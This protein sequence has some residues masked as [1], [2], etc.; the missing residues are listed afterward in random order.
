MKQRI[1]TQKGITLIALIIT[2]IV[3][4]IL[5]VV[6]IREI[7]GDGIIKHAKEAR[8][9]YTVGQEK[10]LIT[11]GYSDYQISKINNKDATLK[12][13]GATVEG[14]EENGWTITFDKTGNSYLLD[15]KG[16]IT[17]AISDEEMFSL[18]EKYF[19]GENKEER[20]V[21]DLLDDNTGNFKNNDIL[22]DADRIKIIDGLVTGNLCIFEYHG[23][24]FSVP[25]EEDTNN[26]I[27]LKPNLNVVYKPKGRE[28][29]TVKYSYD[30]TKEHEEE[31]KIIY[32]YG[33]SVEIVPTTIFGEKIHLGKY[34]ESISEDI[35]DAD[36]RRLMSY[37]NAF[38][39]LNEYCKSIVTN[40]N[41]ERVR[42][43]GTNPEDPYTDEP[44][45]YYSDM[46]EQ[47]N[48]ELNGKIKG[49]DNNSL[50]DY[51]RKFFCG[52]EWDKECWTAT[53]S[54]EYYSS[55]KYGSCIRFAIGYNNTNYNGYCHKSIMCISSSEYGVPGDDL[56]YDSN[57]K[58]VLPVVKI[59][60]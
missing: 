33:D 53:R 4:L 5:A 14:N 54:I 56:Y 51:T 40:P 47:L 41:K 2:I 7:T 49:T 58:Y 24:Y 44:S 8:Q 11:L 21:M 38:E 30:G 35:T 45:K 27:I 39:R 31:W 55:D 46:L 23:V 16:E 6:A 19:F 60:Y 43:F 17:D 52:I 1:K 20:N 36:E 50:N 26:N 25:A 29:Q 12:V 15:V 28:G 10:E 48:K 22:S 32:D 13:E 37:N 57:W 18:L 34:D 9:N 42:S 3:L 59:K